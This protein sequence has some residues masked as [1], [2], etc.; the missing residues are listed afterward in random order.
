MW[1]RYRYT[2]MYIRWNEAFRILL[3]ISLIA[4]VFPF[5]LF[6]WQRS[7]GALVSEQEWIAQGLDHGPWRGAWEGFTIF[8]PILVLA[9]ITVIVS[10]FFAV[11]NARWQPLIGG[12]GLIGLQAAALIIQIET[13][14]WLID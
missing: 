6:A 12:L 14:V 8:F 9:P 10:I 5:A 11:R 1:R 13:L 7:T 3:G 4:V 2:A